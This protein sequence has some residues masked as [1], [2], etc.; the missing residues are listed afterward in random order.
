MG[1]LNVRKERMMSP[2]SDPTGSLLSTPTDTGS[3]PCNPSW[4]SRKALL[5]PHAVL[6]L[7]VD[8]ERCN[9]RAGS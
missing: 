3:F 7:W 9:I 6:T 8:G 4:W 1:S 2:E 5:L